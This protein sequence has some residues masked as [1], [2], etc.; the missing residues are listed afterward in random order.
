MS[1]LKRLRSR[2]VQ[3]I[4]ALLNKR[5]KQRFKVQDTIYLQKMHQGLIQYNLDGLFTQDNIEKS[6]GSLSQA[7][8]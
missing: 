4:E 8:D 7:K 3:E 5:L 2:P 1:D 6:Q